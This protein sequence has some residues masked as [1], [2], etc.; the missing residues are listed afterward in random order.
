[1]SLSRS[2]SAK[3]LLRCPEQF[4]SGFL[5]LRASAASLGTGVPVSSQPVHPT[6]VRPRW[7]GTLLTW[8]LLQLSDA[9]DAEFGSALAELVPVLAWQP[10]RHLLPWRGAEREEML[11]DPPLRVRQFPLLRGYSRFPI[12]AVYDFGAAVV[13]R[14]ARQCEAPENCPLICT[15]PFFASVAERWPGPV[16]YWLTDLIAA[17]PSTDAD[18]VRR[19]DTYMC[20]AADLVCPNSTRL[21]GYLVEQAGCDPTKIQVI[22][23]ATRERNLLA[24]PPAHPAELPADLR[25][26]PRPV[27]GVMGNLASNLDWVFLEQMIARAPGFSW[28]F[29]GPTSMPVEDAAQ[30]TARDAVMAHPRTRFVGRKPYGDL[31]AYA[32]AFDA[33]VLPYLR[34]EP[35]YSGSSTRFYEHL[36]AGQP[37]AATRG[38]EELLH[39]EPLLRLVDSADDAAAWLADLQAQGFDDGLREVRWRASLE[40]TWQGRARLMQAALVER[41]GSQPEVGDEAVLSPVSA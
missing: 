16:I 11:T 41:L 3:G 28:A 27:A 38:F 23:N 35:T 24:A 31:A 29:V 17:Y 10:V 1:M 30:R 4:E 22:P 2:H 8:Q 19:L 40:A 39:K 9:L 20:R 33:A 34:V 32:R 14:L 26:L 12:S 18:Q 7:S 6:D 15:T 36:A 5:T 25:D 21:A 37:I 13:K